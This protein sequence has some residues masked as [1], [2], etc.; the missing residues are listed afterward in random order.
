M[1]TKTDQGVA[2]A[3]DYY[4][5]DEAD[6]FYNTIWG[7]EDIHV[8]IYEN[9]SD[10]RTASRTTV[11]R[12]AQL[13]GDVNG[14]SLLDIGSGYG[15]AARVMASQHGA[16]VTCLNVAIVENDRNREMTRAAGLS[17]RIEVVDGSFDDLPFGDERFDAAWSQDAILHAPDR[18]A[19]LE[20]VARVLRPGGHFIFTDPMQ[21]DDLTDEGDLQPIYDRIHLPNLASFGFYRRELAR[22]GFEEVEIEDRSIELRNHYAR[23]AEELDARR[24]DVDAGDAWVNRM[25]EGL[26]HWVK[27][28]DAGKLTWGILHFRKKG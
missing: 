28:A 20:E 21:A 15:G 11:D 4:D 26:S 9:T 13:L 5:S 2:T 16:H 3:R 6:N 1:A 17:D 12:M 7:G 19:V 18:V 25:L 23:V 8:G 14:K 10:I 22:L 27:G 24:G